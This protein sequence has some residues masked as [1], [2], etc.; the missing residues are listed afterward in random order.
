MTDN[1]AIP[2]NNPALSAL[3]AHV[4]EVQ[5]KACRLSGLVNAIAYLE[6]EKA[7][8][9]GKCALIY[10][11]EELAEEINL[12]LDTVSLPKVAA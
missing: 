8:E 12:A 9:E 11:A 7:C 2:A 5:N 10:L 4:Q 1:N 3:K 6:G